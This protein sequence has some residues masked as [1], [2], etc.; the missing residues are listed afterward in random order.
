[1]NCCSGGKGAGG[2]RFITRALRIFLLWGLVIFAIIQLKSILKV[3][4]QYLNSSL[5]LQESLDHADSTIEAIDEEPFIDKRSRLSEDMLVDDIQ[6]RI[7]NFPIAYWNKN[8]SKPIGFNKTC[9]RFPS[10]FDL[11]F[12]NIY[13]QTLRTTN[14]TFQLFGAYLDARPNNRLGPTVRILGMIDRIQPTVPTYCQ[15]WFDGTKEPVIVKSLEYKYIWNKGWGNYQQGIY[16]PYLI[17]CV[18]PNQC[19]KAVPES[20]SLVEKSC[21]NASNNLRVIYNKPKA[22][23][24]FAV[25]VK[26]LD[27]LYEDLSVRLVEWI[28]LLNLLG[29]DKIFFY[30]LQVHPNISKVLKYYEKEG[31]VKVTPI[32]LAGGQPNGPSFQHLYLTKKI[33]HKRQN[34]VIP[35]NDCFYKHMY[36]YKYITLLDIDEVI[37]PI[38]GTTWKELMERVLPKAL[39][40][41]KEERAS[42]N[43]RNVYFL[44]DMQHNHGWFKEV[45][46]YMHMLQHVYRAKNFTKPGAY[47]KCFHNTEK[48]LIL[49]NHFPFA[50]LG[51]GCTTYPINTADAQL[52]HYRADCVDDLKQ[53]CEGFKNNSVMDVTIWKFK[54]PLIARVSTALRTLGYFTSG[55]KLE[56]R[57]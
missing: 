14:G 49:H 16:Q 38:D 52:Q 54:Q 42:Y 1:M 50:C 56:D 40:I 46:R 35:Y 44:D 41:N 37:M 47:V 32:N 48:V 10:M 51:S 11:E 26:G 45:P 18:I 28:E 24:D 43:V 23:K 33:I 21:D 31:K 4:V 34:E 7:D 27:F 53:K 9:A 5:Q 30:E 57:R 36:E 22:K 17:A 6:K 25:C 39:K 2:G 13:W 29:A 19:Q 12:N 3:H 55:K 20:V 8:K 15:F